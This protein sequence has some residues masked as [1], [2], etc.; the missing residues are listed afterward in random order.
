MHVIA[1]GF[2]SS[3]STLDCIITNSSESNVTLLP[4][5]AVLRYA[6]FLELPPRSGYQDEV[7]EVFI[8]PAVAHL[9]TSI[10][11]LTPRTL[12][13]FNRLRG[14]SCHGICKPIIWSDFNV[15]QCM[16]QDGATR[17]IPILCDTVAGCPIAVRTYASVL[18]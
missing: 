8:S 6:R 5:W 3:F 7:Y 15:D 18:F 4:T 13:L 11:L 9:L 2:S 1:C 14:Q 17:S 16:Y 10:W 12:T